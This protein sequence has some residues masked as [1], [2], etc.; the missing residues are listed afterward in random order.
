MKFE[1]MMLVRL[2]YEETIHLLTVIAE[3]NSIDN[4]RDEGVL[5]LKDPFH[6]LSES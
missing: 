6:S 5:D 3:N 4:L 2:W 1:S